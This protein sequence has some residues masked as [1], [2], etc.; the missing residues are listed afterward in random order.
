MKRIPFLKAGEA[1]GGPPVMPLSG[2]G[3]MLGAMK[4]ASWLLLLALLGLGP[5]PL[6]GLSGP[7]GT[8][9]AALADDDDDDDNDDDDDGPARPAPRPVTPPASTLSA[10]ARTL[11]VGSL[12]AERSGSLV[13]VRLG[14]EAGGVLVGS[15]TLSPTSLEPLTYAQRGLARAGTAPSSAALRAALTRLA[16]QSP[17]R[18][19]TGNYAAGA[20]QGPQLPVY[21]SGR[22]VGYL[23]LGAQG[24]P[25]ADAAAQ[26]SLNASALKVRR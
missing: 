14:L 13:T 19:S 24:K 20:P 12:W 10:V 6:P 2:A 15:L 11:R 3:V 26:R 4:R 23:T 16:T 18:L 21:W 9:G 22:L 25:L 5:L 1:S 7:L 17:A 8:L